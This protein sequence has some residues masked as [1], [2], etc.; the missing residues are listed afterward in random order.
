MPTIGWFSFVAPVELPG[1]LRA[2]VEA[3][4]GEFHRPARS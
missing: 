4:T 3:L 2:E 1:L